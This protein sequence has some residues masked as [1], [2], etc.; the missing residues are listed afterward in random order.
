MVFGRTTY[1][2]DLTTSLQPRHIPTQSYNITQSSAPDDG[3]MV[4]RNMLINNLKRNKEYKKRHLVGFSYPHWITMHGQPHI[5]F[6]VRLS[7]FLSSLLWRSSDSLQYD[8]SIGLDSRSIDYCTWLSL[9]SLS[10]VFHHPHPL[11]TRFTLSIN[12][13]TMWGGEV[14]GETKP[15][16]EGIALFLWNWGTLSL[17]GQ[18][19]FVVNSQT[20][21]TQRIDFSCLINPTGLVTEIG[22]QLNVSPMSPSCF[23]TP[24]VTYGPL[25]L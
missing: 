15:R 10:S 20:T 13:K 8:N 25:D 24:Y 22:Y 23:I 4:A 16:D 3:H 5:R 9:P 19:L 6:P 17:S 12:W 1:Q 7:L 18:G 21:W 2:P 11:R 14:N